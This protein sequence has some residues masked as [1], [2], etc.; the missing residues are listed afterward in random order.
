MLLRQAQC[1]FNFSRHFHSINTYFVPTIEILFEWIAKI[2]NTFLFS[3]A[4]MIYFFFFVLTSKQITISLVVEG[5]STNEWKMYFS[6]E[7]ESQKENEE[8][9]CMTSGPLTSSLFSHMRNSINMFTYSNGI[10][11]EQSGS[12]CCS[13]S[14]KENGCYNT[15][16]AKI[17]FLQSSL[18]S[19]FY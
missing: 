9:A 4:L 11:K 18:Y 16:M 2:A 6:F 3:S 15:E 8:K 5:H 19:L 10:E 14:C 12:F 17:P 7:N 13:L 1:S